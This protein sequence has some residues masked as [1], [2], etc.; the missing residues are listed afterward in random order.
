MPKKNDDA[1]KPKSISKSHA[2]HSSKFLI[3]SVD[4]GT[5]DFNTPSA[6]PDTASGAPSIS[7]LEQIYWTNPL[8]HKAINLR[9][10]KI[11]G[12]G[13]ELVATSGP[14]INPHLAER[15]RFTCEQFC[16]KINYISFFRQSIINAYVGGNEW[17]ELVYNTLTPKSLV[18]L[19]HGDFRTMDFRRDYLNKKILVDG[20]GQPVGY[21]QFIADLTQLYR[22]VSLL[23][24]SVPSY[25]DFVKAKERLKETQSLEIKDA[26]GN[27]LGVVLVKPQYMFVQKDE[28]AHLAFNMLNDNFW[29]VSAILAAYDAVKRLDMVMNATAETVNEMGFQ[30]LKATVGDKDHPANQILVDQVED[31]IKDPLRKEGYVLPYPVDL[32]YLST[33]AAANISTY[34]QWFVTS[35]AIGMKIPRELLT[36]EGEANRSTAIQGSTDFEKDCEADRRQLERYIQKIFGYLLRS[37][38]FAVDDNGN[39]PYAPNIKW[40]AFITEDDALRQ[41]MVLEKF[42]AGLITFSEARSELKLP[43]IEDPSRADK[44]ADELKLP[45]PPPS[46]PTSD[47]FISQA[48]DA[49]TTEKTSHA[50]HR[51]MNKSELNPALDTLI[52]TK[53]IDYKEI[54]QHD[55][56]TEI[57]SVSEDKAKQ[58][59]DVLINGR[60][61]K[62]K[63]ETIF[64]RI[65]EIGGYEDWEVDRIIKTEGKALFQEAHMQYAAEQGY[66]KKMW[67]IT[68][69][70]EQSDACTELNGKIVGIDEEFHAK[71]A[72]WKG[73][74]PPQHPNC[75]CRLVFTK[76]G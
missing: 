60:A 5:Y 31:M 47:G 17:T 36:G 18:Y 35:V 29:G 55:I 6:T 19:S 70:Q 75:K 22:T 65:K 28:V 40:T 32:E 26:E 54:A 49:D 9:A 3:P 10:N 24:G 12:D 15:A 66:N 34:P 13:F 23:G 59:R 21:Q 48:K 42:Q 51:L 53:G 16:K 61:E 73:M 63:P 27:V 56:A 69:E 41:K 45:S 64:S 4:T 72:N 37:R 14:G 71:H 20:L 58:I 46:H 39:T 57:K 11:I 44:F 38:G 1:V 7:D 68:D 67:E 30:K 50:E 74:K 8:I 2:E 76:G 52:G 33:T 62:L 25:E 43:E